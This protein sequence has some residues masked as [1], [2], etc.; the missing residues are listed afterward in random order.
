MPIDPHAQS[1][2]TDRIVFERGGRRTAVRLPRHGVAALG[3]AVVLLAAWSFAAGGYILFHDAVVAALRSNAK[4]TA[5]GYEAQIAVLKDELERS[6]T[7]RMVERAGVEDRLGDLARRQEA[8]EQRQT[9]L[10]DLGAGAPSAAPLAVQPAYGNSLKPTPLDQPLES[11]ED[12]ESP[13]EGL[14]TEAKSPDA[15]AA[16]LDA[17]ELRQARAL[18]DI[19]QKTAVRRVKLERVYNA[20]GLRKP[21]PPADGRARGGPYEPAPARALS[22]EAKAAQV[23][24]E[25]D[26]VHALDRGLDRAPIRTPAPGASISSGFGVRPDPFLGRPAYH[27]GLDFEETFG[28]P[29]RA[30]AAGRVIAAG[31]SGGYGNM[32]EIDH[33]GGLTTR[34]GHM[35]SIAVEIGQDVKPGSTL[36]R[37]GSTGRSTGPHL[38][39]ET[40]VDGEAVDPLRFLR[41]G[42]ILV[43]AD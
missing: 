43:S 14:R 26:L 29:V 28:S 1:A 33:G 19:A 32:V 11:L 39:Y 34:F 42:S 41:A 37:V 35:S 20:A 12:V 40:R 5:Q 22:F 36:G 27:A 17:L 30:T 3:I 4:A 13:A 16:S 7:R 31:P 6:R 8:L 38:H 10:A 2:A 25:R 15:L 23:A 18:N 21:A 24:A 9:K